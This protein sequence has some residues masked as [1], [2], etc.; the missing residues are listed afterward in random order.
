M[1]ILVF[2]FI[3]LI[4]FYFTIK[5]S[6]YTYIFYIPTNL[7]II[8]I[9][10]VEI[11]HQKHTQEEEKPVVIRGTKTRNIL[12]QRWISTLLAQVWDSA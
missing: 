2:L 8:Y 7:Y 6:H 3:Y 12:G 1:G 4:V 11:K 5:Q 10:A 9:A